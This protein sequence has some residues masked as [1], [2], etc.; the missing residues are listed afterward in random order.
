MR[1][2][3]NWQRF[4]PYHVAR[5]K[6]AAERLKSCGVELVGLETASLD[7]IY[8]WKQEKLSA[9]FPH[10]VAFPNRRVEEIPPLEVGRQMWSVLGE[11]NPDAAAIAGFSA[12]DTL[13]MLAWCKR[14]NRPAILMSE[15]KWDDSPRSPAKEAL[16]SLIVRQYSAALCGGT[17]HRDYLIRL[18]MPPQNIFL[19]YD[20]VDNDYFKTSAA[21]IRQDVSLARHLPGLNDSTPFFLASSRFIKRKNLD[22]LLRAYSLYRKLCTETALRPW[23]LV[24]LGDGEERAA[25]ERLA[26]A[27]GLED[28]AVCFAG[29]QQIDELPAYYALAS[30]FIHPAMQEQ[31]GLVVNE[32]MA[33]GVPVLV[34]K[35]CGC[36][37][38]LII[39][40]QTG[41]TFAPEKPDELAHLM[42]RVSLPLVDLQKIGQAAQAHIGH[43][44]LSHFAAGLKEALD[45]AWSEK[46]KD[47]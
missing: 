11:L 18:G 24:L 29:F 4:G 42:M 17:P 15:S 43:W 14:Y 19:G 3:V 23:R 1:L 45:A 34:S 10:V 27:E 31:W 25:L 16:K 39:E 13:A 38:D 5:L 47:R 21:R 32:A 40:G 30:A 8:A 36:A 46:L 41:F 6:A 26:Q 44:G 37:A 22:S 35:R 9:P 12:A 2:V 33:S 20:A 7:S 28:E